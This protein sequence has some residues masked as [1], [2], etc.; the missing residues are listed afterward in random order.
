MKAMLEI[1]TL[2]KRSG[3]KDTRE[4]TN[5]IQGIKERISDVDGTIEDIDTNGKGAKKLTI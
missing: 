4:Y 1:E 3:I 5:R 2:G